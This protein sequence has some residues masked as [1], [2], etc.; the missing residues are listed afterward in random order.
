MRGCQRDSAEPRLRKDIAIMQ[1][2]LEKH[3]LRDA[4][5]VLADDFA[6]EAGIVLRCTTCCA[7][8]SWSMAGSA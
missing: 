3:R 1:Q 7:R 4:M 2:A 6:G 5:A 8:N